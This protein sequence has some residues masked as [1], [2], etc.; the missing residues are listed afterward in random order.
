M[1]LTELV[2]RL[3]FFFTACEPVFMNSKLGTQLVFL[4]YD[5]PTLALS[6]KILFVLIW[7]LV[8]VVDFGCDFVCF[9]IKL[10]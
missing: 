7:G 9:K 3:C 1:Y 2:E 5:S 8:L 10:N 6:K 4:V